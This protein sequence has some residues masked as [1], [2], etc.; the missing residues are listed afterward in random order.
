VPF[1]TEISRV[2]ARKGISLQRAARID[3]V[4][5]TTGSADERLLPCRAQGLLEY[6]Y[7][8]RQGRPCKRSAIRLDFYLWRALFVIGNRRTWNRLERPSTTAGA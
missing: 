7:S 2:T 8:S 3:A 4:A 1:G 5:P 6:R